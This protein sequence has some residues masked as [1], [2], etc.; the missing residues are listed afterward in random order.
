MVLLP[1]SG[2]LLCEHRGREIG[3][4]DFLLIVEATGG[5]SPGKRP[6][7]DPLGT[8]PGM[9]EA[10][11][12]AHQEIDH[13]GVPEGHEGLEAE[14]AASLEGLLALHCDNDVLEVRD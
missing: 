12:R 4:Q 14:T 5:K 1:G 3:D 7:Q 13:L 10:W 6:T 8:L 11:R 9:Q 2:N